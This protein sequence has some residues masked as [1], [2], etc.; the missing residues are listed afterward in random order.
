MAQPPRS[1]I[2]EAP[3]GSASSGSNM[4]NRGDGHSVTEGGNGGRPEIAST[5]KLDDKN[6]QIERFVGTWIGR[7][8]AGGTP[9]NIVLILT[10]SGTALGGDLR[11]LNLPVG[12][13]RYA[14]QASMTGEQLKLSLEPS[15][16]PKNVAVPRATGRAV[17]QP[18]GILRGIWEATD[19]T[20]GTFAAVRQGQAAQAQSNNVGPVMFASQTKQ[21]PVKSCAVDQDTLKR[22]FRDMTAGA[23]DATRLELASTPAQSEQSAEQITFQQL[24]PLYAV[25]ITAQGESGQTVSAI[26][27]ADFLSTEVL[28]KPLQKITFDLGF[29]YRFQRQFDAPNRAIVTLDFSKPPLFDLTSPSGV[30][31]PNESNISV[32][33][34]DSVWVAGIFEK[35]TST[36]LQGRVK[37]GWLHHRHIYDVL[38][39]IVGIPASLALSA[40]LTMKVFS[41]H[42]WYALAFFLF[43]LFASITLFRLTFSFARWLL[44]Y[45]EFSTVNQ[46]VHRQIRVVLAAIAIGSL[47]AGIARFLWTLLHSL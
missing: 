32:L 35:L 22:L 10:S 1:E 39:L 27:S 15:E 11:F 14:V 5:G 20:F 9:A 25:T 31:T 45:I 7:A 23:Q 24:R 3:K 36:L 16:N 38:L 21:T 18:D 17:L 19:N 29:H 2:P 40:A 41:A 30:P 13:V 6:E 42:N 44:P 8:E 28:P 46:P 33:G 4:S 37:T 47:P 12:Q 26:D 34:R 43:V